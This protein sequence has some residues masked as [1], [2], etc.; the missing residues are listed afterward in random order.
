MTVR[1][2]ISEPQGVADPN[3]KKVFKQLKNIVENITARAPGQTPIPTLAGSAN[4][5]GVITTVNKVI[6]QLQS[7][8]GS[9]QNA[10]TN[11]GGGVESSSGTTVLKVVVVGDSF[12]AQNSLL[13][14]AWPAIFQRNMGEQGAPIEVVNLAIDGASFYRAYYGYTGYYFGTNTMIEQAIAEL[15]DLTI[16]MMGFNDR[17]YHVDSRTLAQTESDAQLAFSALRTGLAGRKIVF[18]S[19]QPY[20]SQNFTVT[21]STNN[22]KNK[23]VLP[24]SFTMNTTGYLAYTY[25]SDILPNAVGTDINGNNVGTDYQNWVAFTTY[26]NALTTLDGHYTVNMWRIARMGCTGAPDFLHPTYTGSTCEAGY[27]MIGLQGQSWFSTMFPQLITNNLAQWNNPDNLFNDVLTTDGTNGYVS[28]YLVEGETLTFQDGTTR[29]IHPTSWYLP[30][31]TRFAINPS[32][33]T[34][35][36]LGLFS[37]SMLNGPPAGAVGISTAT[38]GAFSSTGETTSWDG[39]AQAI[40]SGASLGLSNGTYTLRYQVPLPYLINS[41]QFYEVYGPFTFTISTGNPTWTNAGFSG[42]WANN[43]TPYYGVQFAKDV[44]GWVNI[45]GIAKGGTSGVVA[46]VIS[47]GMWPASSVVAPAVANGTG[48]ACLINNT[49]GVVPI[50]TGTFSF[51]NIRFWPG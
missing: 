40:G 14:D 33:I 17:I 16:V 21:S 28:Q 18:A 35:D 27:N 24:F 39:F 2:Q 49:G 15:G 10:G 4:L 45:R 34:N 6:N 36:A 29:Q 44:N 47:S 22:L 9:A 51:D 3:A 25:C 46:F 20:D 11:P 43:G 48:A 41:I 7:N 12:S 23:G 31:K 32:S 8:E 13:R 19:E 42:G 26:V 50:G 1:Q 5:G 37:W 38:N 30:Y